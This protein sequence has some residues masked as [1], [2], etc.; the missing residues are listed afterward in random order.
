MLRSSTGEVDRGFESHANI[1]LAESRQ[2]LVGLYF[3]LFNLCQH[4]TL[5]ETAVS[6]EANKAVPAE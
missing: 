6:I 2:G 3:F 5:P 1:T 4:L